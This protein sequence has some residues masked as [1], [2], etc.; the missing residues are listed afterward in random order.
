MDA[1]C[2]A[3]RPPSVKSEK[4]APIIH[5]RPAPRDEER[6]QA[7][8][9]LDLNAPQ[10]NGTTNTHH[11]YPVAACRTNNN[12]NTKMIPLMG[13]FAVQYA[14]YPIAVYLR[15]IVENSARR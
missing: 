11:Q 9:V 12:R 6:T 7:I 4:T 5:S 13:S 3:T 14:A 15:L 1:T 8:D 2:E 10:R